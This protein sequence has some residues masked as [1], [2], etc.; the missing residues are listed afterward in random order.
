VGSSLAGVTTP[1]LRVPLRLERGHLATVEQDTDEELAQA[2]AV[3]LGTLRGE[4]VVVPE[5]GVTDLAYR[6]D[7]LSVTELTAAVQRW[8][9][10]CEVVAITG[11]QGNRTVTFIDLTDP[12]RRE[13]RVAVGGPVER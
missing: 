9:P 1:H 12:G 6:Q 3:I 11:P 2:V 7:E 4:R 10:R 5:F 13:L 8:D